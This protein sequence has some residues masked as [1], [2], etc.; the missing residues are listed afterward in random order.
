MKAYAIKEVK[1][2]MSALLIGAAFDDFLISEG[3]ITTFCT[4]TVDGSWQRD[5]ADPDH[6]DPAS[7]RRLAAWKDVR[8]IFLELIKGKR[9]P[10]A[11]KMVFVLSPEA[12]EDLIRNEDLATAPSDIF[13]LYMNLTFRDGRLLLTTGSSFRTFSM[14]RSVDNA[15]DA[16]VARFFGENGIELESL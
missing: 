2:C 1:K 14:D 12:L 11:F 9:T 5:F 10:L 15:W 3:S 13:G 7:E 8:K 6:E 4:W 16:Y